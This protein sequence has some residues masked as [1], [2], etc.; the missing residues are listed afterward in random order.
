[1][2]K[3]WHAEIVYNDDTPTDAVEFEELDELQDLVER[4]P[5][6]NTIDKIIVTLNRRLAFKDAE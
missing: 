6:W 5:D 3:R 4:G 2:D 1:M